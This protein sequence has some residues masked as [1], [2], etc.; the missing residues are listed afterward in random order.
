MDGT[1]KVLNN[2][3]AAALIG[4]SPNTLKLWRHEGKGPPFIKFGETDG[5]HWQG[6]DLDHVQQNGL[7]DIAN[8]LPGYVE[9]SPSGEG[10]HAIGYG[11]TFGA[12]GSNG[13]GIEAYAA[14][15]YFTVT[16]HPIRDG[17]PAC[18]ASFVAQALASRHGLARAAANPGGVEVV[19]VDDGTKRDLRSALLAMRAD[20]YHLWI[21]MGMALRELGE[22][23][24]ALWME[25]SATSAD[26]FDAREA[27][28]KWDKF[29][30][31]GTGYQ[32]VFAEAQR[33][34]WLNPAS[35]A[36]QPAPAPPAGGFHDRTELDRLRRQS[37]CSARVSSVRPS[38]GKPA[39]SER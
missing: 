31:S 7:A 5:G 22:A 23:G 21:R 30:P 35:S 4:I 15:R 39:V 34:E 14:G 17:G 38:V 29:N 27:A 19:P 2:A 33:H 13:S 37:A 18:L 28:R 3:E 10:A 9:K 25:W 12:L 11:Q 6:I 20:D 16:E 26:K 36:A 1:V 24:R 32:A 8:A